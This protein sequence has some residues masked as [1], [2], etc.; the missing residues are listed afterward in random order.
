MAR[1]AE[2]ARMLLIMASG[3]PSLERRWQHKSFDRDERGADYGAS[4]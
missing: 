1:A 2:P 4:Q 3:S